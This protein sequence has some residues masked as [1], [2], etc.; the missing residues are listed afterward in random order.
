MQRPVFHIVAECVKE[1]YPSL[2]SR[3]DHGAGIWSG[4]R[5]EYKIFAGAGPGVGILNKT[6]SRT[7]S[8]NFQFLQGPDYSFC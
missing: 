5:P 1:L 4:L 7:W 8:R 6:R 2:C 3:G